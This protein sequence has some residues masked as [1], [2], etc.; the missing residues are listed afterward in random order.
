MNRSLLMFRRAGIAFRLMARRRVGTRLRAGRLPFCPTLRGTGFNPSGKRLRVLSSVSLSAV[1]LLAAGCATVGSEWRDARRTDTVQ[2]Y[3]QF[4]ERHGRSRFATFARRRLL[5]VRW[6]ELRTSTDIDKLNQF[7]KQVDQA[8]KNDKQLASVAAQVRDRRSVVTWNSLRETSDPQPVKK[9]LKDFPKSS[10]RTEAENRLDDLTWQEASRNPTLSAWRNY[11]VNFPQGR[12]AAEVRRLAEGP[13]WQEARASD[14]EAALREHLKL[15]PS[16]ATA[17]DARQALG[18]VV[19]KRAERT[20][21]DVRPYHEYL[22]LLPSGPKATQAQDCVDWAQAEQ[23]GTRKAVAQ[24]LRRH[25]A[26]RFAARARHDLSRLAGGLP[27]DVAATTVAATNMI[28]TQ[29]KRSMKQ[30]R[31][32]GPVTINGSAF[33]TPKKI[34]LYWRGANAFGMFTATGSSADYSLLCSFA[35]LI[36]TSGVE[37]VWFTR[38]TKAV[39]TVKG[40]K[41]VKTDEGW[42]PALKEFYT[43]H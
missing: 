15:F 27:P 5:T 1:V 14:N 36:G 23:E 32:T 17:G 25:P 20:K 22:K 3:H 6:G 16:G 26:G 33:I 35:A 30:F 29:L 42:L 8:A 37:K 9:F 38:K 34:S 28:E 10:V 19:W 41:Y 11:L 12:H 4:L 7:Q 31:A 39:L 2:A 40:A 43:K 18:A 21:T 13:S 24:Y